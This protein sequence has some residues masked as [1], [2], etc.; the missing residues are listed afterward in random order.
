ME[1][2]NTRDWLLLRRYVRAG[3]Q[4]AF[5]ALVDRYGKL[6]YSTCR[7]TVEDGQLA[8]DA[9]QVV[10]VL[11]SRKAW[12]FL[13]GVVLASWLYKTARYVASD[14]RRREAK[15]RR[16]EPLIE[17]LALHAAGTGA[18]SQME[19]A[20]ILNGP[21]GGNMPISAPPGT[22]AM[23]STSPLDD[24]LGSLSSAEWNLIHLRFYLDF[25]MKEVGAAVGVSEDTAQKRV[26]RAL[27]RMRRTMGSRGAVLTSA[28]IASLLL[29]S[30]ARPAPA[31][32]LAAL[33]GDGGA[34]AR[35]TSL[36]KG[37]V[38]SMFVKSAVTAVVAGGLVLGCVALLSTS[39]AA[40]RPAT[41][42]T[43]GSWHLNFTPGWTYTY[44][45][46]HFMTTHRG[47]R[48]DTMTLVEKV[49]SVAGDGTG[50]LECAPTTDYVRIDS[51]R[52]EKRSTYP[53][54]EFTEVISPD[55]SNSLLGNGKDTFAPDDAAFLPIRSVAPGSG[56]DLPS[57]LDGV[58]AHLKLARIAYDARGYRV[59]TITSHA[60][61]DLG[62]KRG[63]IV[64][65]AVIV[66]NVD[67]GIIAS[68]STTMRIGRSGLFT[69]TDTYDLV[70]VTK[71]GSD[72]GP[73][74]TVHR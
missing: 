33:T 64:V 46:R 42:R 15:R 6:V 14:F 44:A 19:A 17:D 52:A 30:A 2:A 70:Q 48:T 25:S 49:S 22:A 74:P 40:I 60:A 41:Q 20:Q 45:H 31:R 61:G 51:N 65:D 58:T 4:T 29:E 10:F 53:F 37:I 66:F 72:S 38:I 71:T 67:Q 62:P 11:L 23:M 63:P 27:D 68:R 69:S 16:R 32:C 54:P 34:P 7:R 26:T 43:A 13:P 24:A 18:N 1:N 47:T 9:T 5:A 59:A 3:D 73:A 57:G 55:G 21:G 8:E 39:H 50:T 36:T 28:A 35:I 12:S 56:W